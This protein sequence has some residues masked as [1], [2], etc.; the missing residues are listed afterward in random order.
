MLLAF[1]ILLNNDNAGRNVR[2][3][4]G[5]IRCVDALAAGAA[6]AHHINAYI[7]GLYV[8]FRFLCFRK[9]GNGNGTG[10]DASLRF[11]RRHPLNP[12]H[13]AFPPERTVHKFSAD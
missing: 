1:F 9:D 2:E 6:C 3:P 10:M 11:R 4:D 12:M 7:I 13:P 5:G 8:D